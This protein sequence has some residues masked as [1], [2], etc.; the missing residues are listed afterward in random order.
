VFF[1]RLHKVL[2]QRSTGRINALFITGQRI[3]HG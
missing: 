3:I 1:A 2:F